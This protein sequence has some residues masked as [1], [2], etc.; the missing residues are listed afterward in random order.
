M[1][2]KILHSYRSHT[3]LLYCKGGTGEGSNCCFQKKDIIGCT[4]LQCLFEWIDYLNGL[5]LKNIPNLELFR[6]FI[7]RS[8]D[9][10]WTYIRRSRRC[11]GHLLN[12]LVRSRYVLCLWSQ[13]IEYKLKSRIKTL[14]I[15]KWWTW[16][17]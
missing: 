3:P 12:I 15:L 13:H 5:N 11:P 16:R 14:G 7:S 9:I 4:L 10:D 17:L 8:E 1:L 6:N 2:N